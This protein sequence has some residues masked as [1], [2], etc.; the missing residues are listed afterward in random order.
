MTYNYL[1]HFKLLYLKKYTKEKLYF[2]YHFKKVKVFENCTFQL[3]TNFVFNLVCYTS[4]KHCV[5]VQAGYAAYFKY[6]ATLPFFF[7]FD[8]LFFFI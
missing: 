1:K 7:W 8:S 5:E 4:R 3:Q 6:P 2:Y